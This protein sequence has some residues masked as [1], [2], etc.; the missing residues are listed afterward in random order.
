MYIF[1]DFKFS[2]PGLYELKFLSKNNVKTDQLSHKFPTL[3]F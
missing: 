3:S 2:F 1:H